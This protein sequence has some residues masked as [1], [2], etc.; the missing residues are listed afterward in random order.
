MY[1]TE[2]FID[3]L[4][5]SSIAKILKAADEHEAGH[6]VSMASCRLTSERATGTEHKGVSTD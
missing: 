4:N 6:S 2:V 3:D 1:I 5:F